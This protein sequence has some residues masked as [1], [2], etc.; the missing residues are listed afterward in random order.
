MGHFIFIMLHLIAVLFGF[1]FLIITIP[2]HLIYSSTNKFTKAKNSAFDYSSNNGVYA[3][4]PFCKQKI[5]KDASK[6]PYCQE[7]VINDGQKPKI[8]D[9]RGRRVKVCPHCGRKNKDD[10]YICMSCSKPI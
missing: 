9:S 3:E 5:N 7:W 4:C 8:V 6:C 10:D 2:L 1:V